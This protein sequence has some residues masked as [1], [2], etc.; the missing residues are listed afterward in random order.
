MRCSIHHPLVHILLAFQ[1]A[2]WSPVMCCCAI[3]GVI[4]TVAGTAA[5]GCETKTCCAQQVEDVEPSC[6]SGAAGM[7]APEQV[8]AKKDGNCRCHERVS[9]KVQL[10][11]GGKIHMPVPQVAVFIAPVD[12]FASPIPFAAIRN[13]VLRSH[14]PPSALLAQRCLLLI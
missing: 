4:G 12:A 10:D 6:C 8:P 11:T 7:D 1:L 5:G 9:A 13:H 3:K 2:L 14:P